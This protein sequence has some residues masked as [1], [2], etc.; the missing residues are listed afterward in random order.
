M[1][2]SLSAFLSGRSLW[3]HTAKFCLTHGWALYAS[4]RQSGPLL[5][6]HAFYYAELGASYAPL[7]LLTHSLYCYSC[8]SV[9]FLE[10]MTSCM[11]LIRNYS[12]RHQIRVTVCSHSC[13]PKDPQKTPLLP[14]KSQTQLHIATYWILTLQK[15]LHKQMFVYYAVNC[16]ILHLYLALYWH[17][18]VILYLC[19][20]AYT[21]YCKSVCDCHTI[22]KCNLLTF[23]LIFQALFI[24]WP[25]LV[26][27]KVWYTPIGPV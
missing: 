6:T 13:P 18:V 21:F 2:K 1:G 11:K 23:L 27:Q 20:Q 9:P 19:L 24:A 25:L 16:F 22:N 14:Q 5:T 8:I 3:T 26:M 7:I 17:F 12:V 4:F 15:L 10:L